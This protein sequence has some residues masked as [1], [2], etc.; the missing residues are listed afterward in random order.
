M[1]TRECWRFIYAHRKAFCD[2]R[3]D[4][5]VTIFADLLRKMSYSSVLDV[6]CGYGRHLLLFAERGINVL[7][8][9]WS[10]TAIL[11][12]QKALIGNPASCKVMLRVLDWRNVDGKFEGV[13][14]WHVLSHGTF[15]EVCSAFERLAQLLLS[16]GICLLNV[17]AITDSRV[18][19]SRRRKDW[20]EFIPQSGT[21]SGIPHV[22]FSTN[23]L[24]N[25]LK[26]ASLNV[27]ES[28]IVGP[29]SEGCSHISVLCSTQNH[30]PRKTLLSRF[31]KSRCRHSA[32]SFQTNKIR[33]ASPEVYVLN[34]REPN[35]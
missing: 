13:L 29:T 5:E 16:H 6:G 11:Q 26:R 17:P 28:H 27:I 33:N 19:K 12:A 15:P 9:D 4:P 3:V 8:A 23:F 14:A 34:W 30:P 2:Q 22:A 21:E 1:D 35:P 20:A 7:G 32:A 10:E 18:E 24:T 25:Q 31:F